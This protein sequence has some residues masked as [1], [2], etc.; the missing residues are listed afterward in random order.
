[1][2]KGIDG[3]ATM[4]QGTPINASEQGQFASRKQREPARYP[5]CL[6]GRRAVCDLADR[7]PRPPRTRTWR[8]SGRL[9]GRTRYILRM[10]HWDRLLALAFGLAVLA[11]SLLPAIWAW[12]AQRLQ[13]YPDKEFTGA[14][15]TYADDAATYWSC[16]S[17]SM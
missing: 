13:H 4:A 3:L 10:R 5:A 8:R 6:C 2:R 14:M 9:R 12:R 17:G 11:A 16:S 15:H 7:R 1:M